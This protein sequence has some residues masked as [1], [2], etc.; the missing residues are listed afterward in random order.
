[1]SLTQSS[2]GVSVAPSGRLTLSVCVAQSGID[3]RL[4]DGIGKGDARTVTDWPGCK[5]CDSWPS[6]Y[7]PA[8]ALL[9]GL[10]CVQFVSL[11]RAEGGEIAN[12]HSDRRCR[13]KDERAER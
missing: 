1:M 13:G 10:S 8:G 11:D 6:R 5:T 3:D 4:M 9:C 2:P 7:V 12:L